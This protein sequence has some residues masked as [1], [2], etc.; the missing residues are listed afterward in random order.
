M[1]ILVIS[2]LIGGWI[3]AS[4]GSDRE[5]GFGKALFLCLVFSPLIGAIF[6]ATSPKV[7]LTPKV[8]CSEC[9]ELVHPDA[10]VCKHCGATFE[11]TKPTPDSGRCPNC[12]AVIAFSSKDC[13]K[14]G[15]KFLGE[16]K[17]RS[18]DA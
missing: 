1:E 9:A 5:I 10:K 15:S 11:P 16:F 8:R 3:L 7:D 14:C 18:I 13:P 4:A 17:V 6:V 12:D 2:W